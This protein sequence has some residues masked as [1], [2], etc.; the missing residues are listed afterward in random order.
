M[1][2]SKN[3]PEGDRIHVS[4]VNVPA[5]LLDGRAPASADAEGLKKV[6]FV[7]DGGKLAEILPAGTPAVAPV[8]DADGGQA[9]PPFADLHTHLDKGQIWPRASN[10]DGTIETA[11]AKSRADTAANWSAK[12]VEARF[13]F[14]LKAAYAYG[15]S[16]IRTHIDCFIPGQAEISFGVFRRLRDRWSGRIALQATSLVSPELYDAAENAALVDMI[17]ESGGRLGGLTFRLTEEE[18]PTILAGRLDRLFALAQSRGLDVD[19]HVDETGM[20]SSTTLAQIAEAVLRSGFRGQVVCGHCCS[21]S[22]QEEGVVARTIGL[23]REAGLNIV[24]LPL[25]NQY[26]QGR[27]PGATPR[28]R[29]IPLLREL[30]A[31]GVNIALA[32]DNCRDTYH[33]FGDLDALEVFG[34]GVRIG[35][36][37]AEMSAWSA[38]VTKTPASIIGGREVGVLRPGANAD[39]QLFA[40]RGFSELLARRQSDR[41]VVRNGRPIDTTLPDYRTLDHLMTDTRSRGRIQP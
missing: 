24:S 31:A 32:S 1:K 27:L 13:E 12:D 14:A 41:I 9:W 26:L 25:V 5:S 3:W 33:P 38:A 35:H 4:N 6:D 28:W 21:L 37:D 34:G 19:L 10:H 16:A 8:F 36:L 40:G 22:V 11:R 30:R 15:T 39:F 7:V 23:V 2:V 17:A 18:D 20:A 29:G